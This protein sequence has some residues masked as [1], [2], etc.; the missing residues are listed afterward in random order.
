MVVFCTPFWTQ[1]YSSLLMFLKWCF[2]IKSDPQKVPCL[3]YTLK[4]FLYV[5]ETPYQPS[6]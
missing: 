4:K 2:S 3:D 1:V 6:I 5:I